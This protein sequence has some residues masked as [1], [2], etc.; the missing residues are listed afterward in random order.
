MRYRALVSFT[1]LVSMAK[2]EVREISDLS[3]AND[4]L[5][6]KYIEEVKADGKGTNVPEQKE[7]PPMPKKTR[8]QKRKE[9][10]K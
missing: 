10:K 2:D 5:K 7:V 3:I 4:L 1:G 9:S 6:A 8:S